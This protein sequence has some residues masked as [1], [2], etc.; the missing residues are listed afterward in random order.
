MIH[1]RVRINHKDGLECLRG[2]LSVS[3][4]FHTDFEIGNENTNEIYLMVNCC[5]S[6]AT[7]VLLHLP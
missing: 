3:E 2:L 5:K 6:F 4:H 1:D 7:D